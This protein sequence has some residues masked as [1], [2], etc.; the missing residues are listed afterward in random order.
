[1]MTCYRWTLVIL[2]LANS[3]Y[4]QDKWGYTVYGY[5]KTD[6]MMDTRQTVSA[7][8]GHV[9]LYPKKKLLTEEINSPTLVD[10][11]DGLNFNIL[12][13]Q[14]RFGYKITAPEFL[15]AKST[16]VLEGEYFGSTNTDVGSVR[17]RHGFLN[18]DWGHHKLLIG[19]FW[20]PLF[21]D[22]TYARVI[23]FNTGIPFVAFGRNPQV[24]YTFQ[25]DELRL[26]LSAVTE[27][28]FPST[29]P[30]GESSYYIRNAGL[31]M[32]NFGAIYNDKNIY[33]AAN[34]CYKELKPRLA[35]EKNYIETTKSRGIIAN[36]LARY[37][38]DDFYVTA[39]ALWGQN[40]YDLLMIGGY[41]VSAID[42][43]SGVWTYTPVDV[44]ALWLDAEYGKDLL[45]GIFLGYSKNHGA[46]SE[47]VGK[48][49]S[50]GDDI[51]YIYRISPRIVYNQGKTQFGAEF[52]YTSAAY[53]TKDKSGVVNADYEVANLRIVLSASIFF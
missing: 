19:Q 41:A 11:N 20:H 14:S 15:G 24:K 16:G 8:E 28:D 37:K 48:Y 18:L 29:G 22:E 34:A 45:L 35:T 40:T 52:E 12:S 42:S 17:L 23:S 33:L 46:E 4:S 26:H 3:L 5:V 50:R 51:D 27:R 49:F 43:V 32:I 21:I 7:R 44:S 47:V 31:P 13:I 36:A 25:Q 38:T 10:A 53:G 30:D 39:S 2:L 9:L 1:M 6:V